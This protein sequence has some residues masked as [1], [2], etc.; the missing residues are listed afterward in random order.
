MTPKVLF[1]MA[2][3][4]GE[5]C[6]VK[7]CSFEGAPPE[8]LLK[9]DFKPAHWLACPECRNC[10]PTHDTVEKRWRHPDFFQ[11]RCEL[12]TKVQRVDCPEHGVR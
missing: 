11:Y 8:L 5:G 4:L 3:G 9:L 6:R 7:S 1:T 12:E 10:G 2:L